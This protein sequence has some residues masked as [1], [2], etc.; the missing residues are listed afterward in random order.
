MLLGRVT[1][2]LHKKTCYCATQLSIVICDATVTRKTQDLLAAFKVSVAGQ[3]YEWV[4]T[5]DGPVLMERGPTGAKQRTYSPFAQRHTPLFV[6]FGQLAPT[7]DAILAFANQYGLLG[8]PVTQGFEHGRLSV[9]LPAQQGELFDAESVSEESRDLLARYRHVGFVPHAWVDHIRAMAGITRAIQKHSEGV[10]LWDGGLLSLGIGY[11]RHWRVVSPDP[12]GAAARIETPRSKE[13]KKAMEGPFI[14]Y[15]FTAMLQKVV[16]PRVDWIASTGRFRLALEPQSLIGCL[17]LQAA[18]AL[19]ER[20]QLRRCI[21]P[22]CSQ[23][24]EISLDHPIGRRTDA[25]FCSDACRARDYR[26]RRAKARVLADRGLTATK[27]AA[28][29]RSDAA[30]VRGWL[31]RR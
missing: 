12:E 27:I 20:K 22:G 25:Q 24:I 28:E 3:G 15:G 17:W 26:G 19:S 6:T 29:L 7:Q 16:T 9:G 10:S 4:S 2:T 14:A 8:A 30:T 13:R 21:G 18:M 11:G 31:K 1:W 23:V 5:L